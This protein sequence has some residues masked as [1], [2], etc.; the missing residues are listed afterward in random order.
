MLVVGDVVP[1]ILLRADKERRQPHRSPS[2]IGQ[3]VEL[4]D[5]T[6]QVAYPVAGKI[7]RRA[8]LRSL[9]VALTRIGGGP[10]TAKA[11]RV[12]LVNRCRIPPRLVRH[13]RSVCGGSQSL[14]RSD[15]CP[16]ASLAHRRAA[17]N[18]LA[19][20][21]GA[22]YHGHRKVHW[23][24]VRRVCSQQSVTATAAVEV[25]ANRM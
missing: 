6:G 5:H 13:R 25:S 4:R 21:A 19:G 2:Q 18:V 7:R 9:G 1:K 8:V 15:A 24:R 12:D 17:G 20:D 23:D 14:V 10:Q 11:S 22:S 16:P 3:V